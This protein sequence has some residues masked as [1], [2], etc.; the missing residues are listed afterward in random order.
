M[1]T[2]W[3]CL[4]AIMIAMYVVLD[5][6][7]LGAGAIHLWVAKDDG[8]RQQV[9]RS[10]GPV[11]DGNEV[12]LLA[13]GGTLYFAFP[14]LYA[15]GFSGFYL[16]L[17]IVL[18]LLILR[19]IAVEFRGHLTGAIWLRFWD[20][21]FAGASLLLAVFYGAALGNVV[22]GV[23]LND[24]GY[25]FEAL[26]TN[27]RVGPNAGVLDWYTIIVGV[28]AL[29]TL[30]LHGALWLALK[31]EGPVHDRSIRLARG[32]WWIVLVLTIAL[33]AITFAVQPE[34]PAN[35]AHHPWGYV[36]PA[37]ALAGLAGIAWF[38][39]KHDELKSFLA[40][41]AYIVGMLTSVVFGL[42]PLVLPASTNPD[43]SLTVD[44]AKAA[45]YGL[46]IG[47]AWWIVGMILVTGYTIHVY[48]SF[49]GKVRIGDSEKGY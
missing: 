23:P 37:L 22:R 39:R 25:F 24:Q 21:V 30:P 19:G 4:V 18:W 10:I 31:T 32:T 41:C 1:Q 43:Y 26:W 48:R 16:P 14:A 11:W 38:M 17:M 12:W 13:A 7:D 8:E 34:I 3:F 2:V 42:Y 15:S 35:L 9:I 33:T 27:F 45:D 6:F 49:A 46:R 28:A 29:V 5:G 36:F 20:V 47:L 44:N 40:S